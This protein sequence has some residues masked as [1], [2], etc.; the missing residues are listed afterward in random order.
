MCDRVRF[1]VR[2]AFDAIDRTQLSRDFMQIVV[3]APQIVFIGGRGLNQTRRFR[4]CYLL[5]VVAAL[6][7]VWNP[8]LPAAITSH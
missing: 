5:G 3:R 7:L 2:R 4:L 6:A 8:A 1:I